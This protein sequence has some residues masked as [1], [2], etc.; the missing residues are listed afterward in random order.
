MVIFS[1][2]LPKVFPLYLSVS[3]SSLLIRTSVILQLCPILLTSIYL[4]YLLKDLTWNMVTFWGTAD[5]DFHTW[6]LGGPNAAH[7]NWPGWGLGISTFKISPWSFWLQ[8]KFRILVL[9]G[10]V[11]ASRNSCLEYNPCTVEFFTSW[12]CWELVWEKAAVS[13]MWRAFDT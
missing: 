7:N 13:K 10:C 1:L 5:Y 9:D 4:N 8:L 2:C 12:K 3:Q 11:L 6:I